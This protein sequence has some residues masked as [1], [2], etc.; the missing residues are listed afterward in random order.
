MVTSYP[1]RTSPVLRGKWILESILD[2]PPPPPPPNVPPLDETRDHFREE[3]AGAVRKASRQSRLARVAIRAWIRWDF[4][5]KI[6]T[7]SGKYRTKEGDSPIDA[8]GNLPDGTVIDGVAGL[9]KVLLAR[10]DEFVEGL[11]DKLLTYALG[12]GL[13]YYDQPAVRDIR[14]Q[15]AD[16]RL[17]VF[18]AG[19]GDRE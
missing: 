16:E 15:A 10:K 12:R 6:S 5:S 14:R 2:A 7:R 17:P 8:S 9:K 3:P 4:R 1:T 18:V 13:E 11:A 19:P